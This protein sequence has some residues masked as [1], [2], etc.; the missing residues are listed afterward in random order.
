MYN[1]NHAYLRYCDGGYYSGQRDEPKMIQQSSIFYRGRSWAQDLLV[2]LCPAWGKYRGFC[3]L[4]LGHF[5]V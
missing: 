3:H 4:Q 5:R 2:G 1:W